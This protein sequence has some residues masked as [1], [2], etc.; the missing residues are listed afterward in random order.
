MRSHPANLVG[1]RVNNRRKLVIALGASAL[2]SPVC[3]F[4][5]Q[6]GRVWRIGVLDTA[7]TAM[8]AENLDAFR[9]RLRELGYV[10]GQ[11]LVIEYRSADGRPERLAEQ[12]IEL[13]RAKVDVIV[14]RGTPASQA[15][16]NATG[17]I[18]IVGHSVWLSGGKRTREVLI[19]PRRESH[20][21]EFCHPRPECEARRA[22]QADGSGRQANWWPDESE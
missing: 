12:A 8:N 9:K 13:V 16:K 10:E 21:A 3:S 2:V 22:D 17:V 7:T 19:T 11:N 18:P 15:A 1:G 4:A 5:Q 6:Q 14:A 20:W